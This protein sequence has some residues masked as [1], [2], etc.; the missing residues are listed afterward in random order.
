MYFNCSTITILINWRI[1]YSVLILRAFIINYCRHTTP[2]SRQP[3]LD[4]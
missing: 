2:P 4:G 1:Y 3:T